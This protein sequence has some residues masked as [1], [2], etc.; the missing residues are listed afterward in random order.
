MRRVDFGIVGWFRREAL[1]RVC[2]CNVVE[3]TW[4]SWSIATHCWLA[5]WQAGNRKICAHMLGR[6][7]NLWNGQQISGS[8][9]TQH[10]YTEQIVCLMIA[11]WN[12]AVACGGGWLHAEWMKRRFNYHHL[13]INRFGIAF[14]RCTAAGATHWKKGQ[15]NVCLILCGWTDGWNI[16]GYPISRISMCMRHAATDNEKR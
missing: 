7:R 11:L 2:I 1:A 6:S 8:D 15:L 5:S 16:R 3:L 12:D 9:W 14:V 13:A 10:K 4:S